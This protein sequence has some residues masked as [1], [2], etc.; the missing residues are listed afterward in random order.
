MEFWCRLSCITT[1]RAGFYFCLYVFLYVVGHIKVQLFQLVSRSFL[2]RC[3]D[4]NNWLALAFLKLMGLLNGFSWSYLQGTG[5]SFLNWCIFFFLLYFLWPSDIS[6]SSYFVLSSLSFFN[7]I[8]FLKRW[9][10]LIDQDFTSSSF[11]SQL[12]RLEW[13]N[14]QPP[15]ITEWCSSGHQF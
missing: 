6:W 9:S 8:L 11:L 7:E 15:P 3:Y 13:L 4:L 14:L 2:L 10:C 12:C 5:F 1:L